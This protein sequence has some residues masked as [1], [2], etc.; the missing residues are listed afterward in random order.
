MAGSRRHS[1]GSF[2][3]GATG[4]IGRFLVARLLERGGT[5]YALVRK[6]SAAKLEALRARWGEA[7]ARVVAVTGDLAR[8]RLGLSPPA[9]ARLRGGIDH[10]FHLAA[11]YDLAAPAGA[12]HEA[13]VVGTRHALEA[14]RLLHARRFHYMSSIAAAG[15]YAGV[16]RED[17]FEEAEGLENPYFRS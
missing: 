11:L 17:M 16:F 12:V 1:G 5:V 8:P 2:V 6:G 10:F 14:A 9:I 3:T 4:F 15:L 13:N 7:G